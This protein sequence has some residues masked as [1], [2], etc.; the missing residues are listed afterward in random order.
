MALIVFKYCLPAL[1]AYTLFVGISGQ[2]MPFRKPEALAE[3][4]SWLLGLWT[5]IAV[6]LT[7]GIG[8]NMAY[9]MN[10]IEAKGL[11]QPTAWL[12]AGILL[13][14]FLAYLAYSRTV[15]HELDAQAQHE[16][17][18]MLSADSTVDAME[19]LDFNEPDSD[20]QL[21]ESLF[22]SRTQHISEEPDFEL[23]AISAEETSIDR[24]SEQLDTESSEFVGHEKS[25]VV[26]RLT[27]GSEPVTGIEHMYWTQT[28]SSITD[29]H[30]ENLV[31]GIEHMQWLDMDSPI[32]ETTTDIAAG[33]QPMAE[34]EAAAEAAAAEAAA[35]EAAAAEAAAAEAAAAEAKKK[36]ELNAELASEVEMLRSTLESE[37]SLR[38]ETEKHLLVTRKGLSALE[39][40]NSDFELRTAQG[41]T[42]L[43]E[44]LEAQIKRTSKSE[45]HA[46]RIEEQ[47]AGLENKLITLQNSVL[48][49]KREIRQSTAA[50]A[51][52]LSTASKS[53][54]FAQ[55]A[56]K[57]RA[58]LEAQVRDT[59]LALRKRQETISSLISAL[60]KEKSR[61]KS[62]IESTAKQMVLH[63]KQLQARRTVENV[64]RNAEGAVSTRLVKKVATATDKSTA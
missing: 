19:L 43:E 51:K 49:A 2:L 39:S 24:L 32:R 59:E 33:G 30:S 11:I 17:D 63:E 14:G 25:T 45:A 20:E 1:L 16:A 29:E 55:Q 42:E 31:T 54:T 46:A 12:L 37:M 62:E 18:L 26:D 4:P 53:V 52:A 47:K 61:T 56:I 64:S 38:E 8:L 44:K 58:L 36:D 7:L 48:E 22:G 40:E 28:T 34:A 57:Q 50:R 15:R 10:L 35:A 23:P 21:E 27:I 41:L 5:A 13:P 3:R 9:Q 6:G 60:E